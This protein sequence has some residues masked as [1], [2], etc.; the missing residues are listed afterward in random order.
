MKGGGNRYL[1]GL[2]EKKFVKIIEAAAQDINCVSTLM[3]QPIAVELR[4][5]RIKKQRQFSRFASAR[6][7]NASL[8]KE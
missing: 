7:A 6:K 8:K 1:S 2:D 5:S 4:D 3:V